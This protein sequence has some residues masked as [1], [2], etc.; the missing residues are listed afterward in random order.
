MDKQLS[1]NHLIATDLDRTLFPN[2]DHAYDLS[3]AKFSEIRATYAPQLAYVSG[4][5]I[6]DVEQGER[7]FDAPRADF[8][9]ASVGTQVWESQAGVYK[10]VNRYA[11][12]V[13]NQD[14]SYDVK[15]FRELIDQH[16]IRTG[17]LGLRLQGEAVQFEFKLSYYADVA[18][19]HEI[20]AALERVIGGV[21][22]ST[23]FVWSED[24][25]E[26]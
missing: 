2:G 17:D 14:P 8:V 18:Q 23:Q 16:M 1:S 12:E 6:E 13:R 5:N 20:L 11:E 21:S 25:D 19:R 15:Q 9:G 24:K 3:M 7:E 26:Q 4:R 10:L 22:P